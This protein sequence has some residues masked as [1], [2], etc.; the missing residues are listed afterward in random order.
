VGGTTA[1]RVANGLSFGGVDV[2]E[3]PH[4]QLMG[5]LFWPVG[6]GGRRLQ[7]RPGADLWAGRAG[8]GLSLLG[9]QDAKKWTSKNPSERPES[10][11]SA[12]REPRRSGD[13]LSSFVPARSRPGRFSNWAGEK[14]EAEGK[15]E[16]DARVYE[17]D[18]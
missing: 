1:F 4:R 13:A 10:P 3:F 14:G 17:L 9:G 8:V 2:E 15:E 6:K 11:V 18:N 12:E 5:D 7:D 16:H